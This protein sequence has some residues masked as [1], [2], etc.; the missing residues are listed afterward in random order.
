MAFDLLNLTG[1][2]VSIILYILCIQIFIF[3]L[4]KKPKVE[5][6][7]GIIFILNIIPLIYL[8]YASFIF[9]RPVI[10]YLQIILMIIFILLELFLDYIFKIDFRNK[11]PLVIIYVMFFYSGLG[12]MIG[13]AGLSGHF[14]SMAAVILFLVMAVLS[15]IQRVKTGM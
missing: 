7:L 9:S 14:W 3:R 6:F 1:S 5:Y 13:I 4:L 2:I 12:G 8:L 15:I 10:Y 11:K